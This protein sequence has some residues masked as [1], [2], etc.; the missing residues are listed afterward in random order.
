MKFSILAFGLFFILYSCDV[1][2]SI[3]PHYNTETTLDYDLVPFCKDKL[4]GYVDRKGNVKIKADYEGLSFFNTAGFAQFKKFGLY[5]VIDRSG[6]E[7]L[8]AF[9]TKPLSPVVNIKNQKKEAIANAYLAIN[10]KA[11][12]WRYFI[13]KPNPYVSPS[14]HPANEK[15]Q[16]KVSDA[17]YASWSNPNFYEGIRRAVSKDGTCNFIDL[18]GNTLLNNNIPYGAP[19]KQ[20]IY[21]IDETDKIG[22]IDLKGNTI[23]P[24]AYSYLE[25]QDKFGYTVATANSKRGVLDK[26]YNLIIDTS[27][28]SIR[29]VSEDRFIVSRKRNQWELVD[30]SLHPVFSKSYTRLSNYLGSLY[31]V[32]DNEQHYLLNEKEEILAGPFNNIIQPQKHADDS[33]YV[34]SKGDN[35]LTLIDNSGKT[36]FSVDKKY[37]VRPGTI[38]EHYILSSIDHG[39]QLIDNTGKV[40]LG[41]AMESIQAAMMEDSYIVKN[42]GEMGIYSAAKDWIIPLGNQEITRFTQSGSEKSKIRIS[43][44]NEIIVYTDSFSNKTVEPNNYSNWGAE[45]RNRKEFVEV[46]FV[47]GR[48]VIF[49]KDKQARIEYTS[50]YAYMIKRFDNKKTLVYDEYMNPILPEGFSLHRDEDIRADVYFIVTNQAYESGL[51][52]IEGNWI[53]PPKARQNVNLIEDAYW[54]VGTREGGHI[55]NTDFEQLSTKQY[56]GF[57]KGK[58]G[59]I[60]GYNKDK[61]VDILDANGKLII[62]GEYTNLVRNETDYLV[63]EKSKDNAIRS[64]QVDGMGKETNCY[65]YAD[66]YIPEN[67]DYIIAKDL[68]DFGVVDKQGV[69]KIPFKYKSISYKPEVKTYVCQSEDYSC[70]LY[71]SNF[72]PFGTSGKFMNRVEK[73]G[74]DYYYLKGSDKSAI[75]DLNGQYLGTTDKTLHGSVATNKAKYHKNGLIWLYGKDASYFF[76]AQNKLLLTPKQ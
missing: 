16:Y 32:Q 75:F 1:Q 74:E 19:S 54:T 38:K 5:G 64:C 4:C 17:Y 44:P 3:I 61:T 8:S 2:A 60:I 49:P 72:K 9:S 35:S 68:H 20:A 30:K 23:I 73:I 40:L 7:I 47:D 29:P 12:E 66:F 70:Q 27:L 59:L 67:T 28:I 57:K 21:V 18:D 33:Q 42:N 6:K 25:H 37:S 10:L 43:T 41:P 14:Y 58:P 24:N 52:D 55:Y 62:E 56:T 39:N 31:I 51:V 34:F 65:P 11:K 26:N 63:L 53:F 15:H 36:I 71:D 50:K 48:Q 76:D 22:A 13:E 69:E 46:N 45:K